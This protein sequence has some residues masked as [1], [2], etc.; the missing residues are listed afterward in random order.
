MRKF[1]TLV[2]VVLLLSASEL[3]A[4]GAHRAQRGGPPFERIEAY[5]KVRMMDAMKLD[6][7][8]MVKFMA[9]Y[10][11]H[12]GEMRALEDQRNVLVDHLEQLVNANDPNAD[13]SPLFDSLLTV[14]KKLAESRVDFLSE[15]KDILTDRQI[16]EYVVFER[17]FSKELRRIVQNLRLGGGR[18]R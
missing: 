11:K 15:L 8:L 13:F 17:N 12:V 16:A 6:E 4:Q 1:A 9:R 10:D 18:P 2:S 5:K 7:G 14:N 3:L